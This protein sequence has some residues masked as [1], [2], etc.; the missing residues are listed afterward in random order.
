MSHSH[1]QNVYASLGFSVILKFSFLNFVQ[2]RGTETRFENPSRH[3]H[4]RCKI[5]RLLRSSRFFCAKPKFIFYSK[6]FL[7]YYFISKQ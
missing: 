4:K 6:E 5:D 3:K 7:L 1:Q 2:Q